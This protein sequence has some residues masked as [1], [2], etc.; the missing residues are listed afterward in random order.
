MNVFLSI[1][2]AFIQFKQGG[3]QLIMSHTVASY[4]GQVECLH[5]PDGMVTVALIC[6]TMYNIKSIR[7]CLGVI[8][9]F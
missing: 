7:L 5:F 4:N 3:V 8:I 6:Y 9:V 1:C 2:D